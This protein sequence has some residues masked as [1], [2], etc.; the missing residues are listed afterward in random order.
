MR[1]VVFHKPWP[2]S[3]ASL[4]AHLVSSKEK[5]G[6]GR[7]SGEVALG[8]EARQPYQ[9]HTFNISRGPADS[10]CLLVVRGLTTASSSPRDP[11]RCGARR[12]HR[13]HLTRRVASRRPRHRARNNKFRRL[14]GDR[15]RRAVR[16]GTK[17]ASSCVRA[18]CIV[19]EPESKSVI[20]SRRKRA[21]RRNEDR[22]SHNTVSYHPLPSSFSFRRAHRDRQCGCTRAF[23]RAEETGYRRFFFPRA[24]QSAIPFVAD[25]N[26]R[27]ACFFFFFRKITFT[28]FDTLLRDDERAN[29]RREHRAPGKFMF[30]FAPRFACAEDIARLV[31]YASKV[32][33]VKH[34]HCTL[35]RA[36]R[37]G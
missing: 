31:Y 15:G 35:G 24:E 37:L 9:S 26:A 13:V 14:L 6:I 20:S 23:P 17:R 4:C 30:R 10:S 25:V 1:R 2:R 28:N 5:H 7:T 16:D 34:S 18:S 36:R 11:S 3:Y 19:R 32:V 29:E 27:A 33:R 22:S 8:E 12:V 21:R